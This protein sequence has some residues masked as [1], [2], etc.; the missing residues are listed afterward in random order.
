[1]VNVIDTDEWDRKVSVLGIAGA[2]SNENS[3]KKG[4]LG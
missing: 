4:R 2:T 1:V 3:K